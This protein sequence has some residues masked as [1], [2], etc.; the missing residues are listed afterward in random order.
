MAHKI[1]D[2]LRGRG[3][4]SRYQADSAQHRR[5]QHS[6]LPPV[7]RAWL[8]E[9]ITY[10]RARAP[11]YDATSTPTPPQARL[12]Q[13]ARLR[14]A[15][16]RF[17]PD[18]HL[19][20]IACGTGEWTLELIRHPVDTITALD[21]SPEMIEIAS[22]KIG[23][24]GRVTFVVSDFFSWVPPQPYDVVAFANFL[25]HVPPRSFDSFWDA[26]HRALAP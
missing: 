15:L 12:E 16:A 7:E 14:D 13:G 17:A 25:S 18:G 4:G 10:Y 5:P 9:Q 19:L 26:V 22:A 1:A 23:G 11:E 24:A 6:D 2:R 8:D 3:L 21:S 20:E